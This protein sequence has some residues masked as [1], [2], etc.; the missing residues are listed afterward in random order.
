MAFTYTYPPP[1]KKIGCVC[2]VETIK[3]MK[4][5]QTFLHVHCVSSPLSCFEFSSFIFILVI[6]FFLRQLNK[7]KHKGRFIP[8]PFSSCK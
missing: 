3:F 2:V 6:F 7:C 8:P 4:K 5:I 1:C